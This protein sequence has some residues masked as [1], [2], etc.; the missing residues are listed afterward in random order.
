MS[1]PQEV[2]NQSNR[3]STRV[4][5]IVLVS[6]DLRRAEAIAIHQASQRRRNHALLP[7]VHQS[8]R[9]CGVVVLWL[10]LDPD[11]EDGNRL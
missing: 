4:V 2:T 3:I 7:R 11:G 5:P 10:V 1:L 9:I 8:S 6:D